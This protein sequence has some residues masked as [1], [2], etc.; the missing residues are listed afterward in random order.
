MENTFQELSHLNVDSL[1]N[2]VLE[3]IEYL[4]LF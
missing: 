2:L 4:I 3:R 1:N